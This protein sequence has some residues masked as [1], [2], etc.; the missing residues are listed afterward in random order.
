MSQKVQYLVIALLSVLLYANTIGNRYSLDDDYVIYKNENV[1]QGFFK[2]VSEIVTTHYSV[3]E[4][5]KFEYRPVVK[6]TFAAE[7]AIWGN[8]PHLSHIINLLLFVLTVL[9]LFKI[10]ARLFG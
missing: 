8:N 5:S 2:T 10:L 1:Q 3:T 6:I 7:Y 9:L 4:K